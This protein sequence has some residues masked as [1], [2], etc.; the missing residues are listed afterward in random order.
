MT[1]EDLVIGRF[2]RY[3]NDYIS[4]I[5]KNSE[6]FTREILVK[7]KYVYVESKD[8]K[9]L[10]KRILPWNGKFTILNVPFKENDLFQLEEI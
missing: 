7:Q 3:T 4:E 8:N 6:E 1:P 2:Y 10:F 9:Y 5:L